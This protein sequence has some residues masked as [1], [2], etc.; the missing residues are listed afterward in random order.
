MT[1]ADGSNVVV[2]A[3]TTGVTARMG[4]AGYG[5]SA[6]RTVT[7]VSGPSVTI[8]KAQRCRA[9]KLLN[10]FTSAIPQVRL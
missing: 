4:I 1:V 8:S 7:N 3:S 5:I 6:N 9:A 2:V 10:P